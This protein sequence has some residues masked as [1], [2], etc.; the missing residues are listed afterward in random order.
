MSFAGPLAALFSRPPI[1]L[2]PMEDVSDLPFRRMCREFGA[3]LTMTE[4]VRAER[5]LSSCRAAARKVTLAP[6]DRPTAIQ[7]YGADAGLLMEAAQ[8]AAAAGPAFVDLNCGCWVPRVARGGA[9]A[10]WLR[11]PAAMVEMAARVVAATAPLPV[12]VKTR[13]GW[14]DEADMPIVDLAR[15]LEDAGVAAITVHCRTAKMGHSGRADWSWA[16]R[17][18][19]AVRIPVVVN[20]DIRSADD[21]RRA[22]DE[23]GAA[24]VMIGRAAIDAPWL[25]AEV[26]ALL[27]RGERLPPLGLSERLALYARVLGD[28]VAQ[29][30]PKFGVLVTRRHAR[31]WF[32]S[33]AEGEALRAQLMTAA[34]E[35][36]CLALLAAC[37]S[38][39]ANA[40]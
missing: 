9:G 20:G 30:G 12:T 37:R 10:S 1:V 25:F 4:F 39:L 5:L 28:N 32:A 35:R 21:A 16:M 14:G 31:A 7:I 8:V 22:L 13:I 36:E 19:R 38:S 15:R 26:R 29:R 34:T 33:F 27:D 2:A 17:V 24:G 23:T 6:D 40:A 18:Q 11:R 3:T